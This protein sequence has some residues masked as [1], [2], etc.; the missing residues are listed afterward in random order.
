VG[1]CA[2]GGLVLGSF[3]NVV[4]ARVPAGQ[5]LWPRSACPRCGA[6]IRWYDNLPLISYAV[7][8]GRCRDC[9]E[10]ISPRYP[11]V[12][13]ATAALFAAAA[14]YFGATPVLP[15][16]LVLAW[17]AVVLTATDLATR[18]LPDAVVLPAYPVLLAL[19]ALAAWA[20][21]TW[22]QFGRA[23]AGGA[24]LAAFYWAIVLIAPRGMGQGDAKLAGL[25]GLGL[26]WLGWGHLLVGAFAAFVLGGAWGVVVLARRGRHQTV[27]FGPWMCAGLALGVIAGAPLWRAY[28]ELCA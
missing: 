11:A 26:G 27:P 7:L 24:A 18:R 19:F 25:I 1:A 3:G 9:H 14:W 17:L 5:S 6:R 13:A 12:E 16:Y 20:G 8:R 21:G 10:P 22:G 23:V 4:I 15:A 28:L 2:I